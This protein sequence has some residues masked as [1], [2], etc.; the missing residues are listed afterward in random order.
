[1]NLFLRKPSEKSTAPSI[2]TSRNIRDEI[3]C[4]TRSKVNSL[5]RLG[6]YKDVPA[7]CDDILEKLSFMEQQPLRSGEVQGSQG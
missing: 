4:E 5:D 6:R 2:N 7:V 1:M 3:Q